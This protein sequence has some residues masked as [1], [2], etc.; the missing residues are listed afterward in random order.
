MDALQPETVCSRCCQRQCSTCAHVSPGP[1]STGVSRDP[2]IKQ[3]AA[4]SLCDS[5][6]S[7]WQA[8]PG[9]MEPGPH[10]LQ[11]QGSSSAC[12]ALRQLELRFDPG[13]GQSGACFCASK[14]APAPRPAGSPRRR[15]P[16]YSSTEDVTL[17]RH[18]DGL[19]KES[20][21]VHTPASTSEDG[22]SPD[23][24]HEGRARD[25]WGF[26]RLSQCDGNAHAVRQFQ[27]DLLSLVSDIDEMM[28]CSGK[29]P[30]E[31]SDTTVSDSHI[32]RYSYD[33]DSACG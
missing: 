14:P 7:P 21:D 3:A 2:Q 1:T 9:S 26:M 11:A 29:A 13:L 18:S 19:G 20:S 6:T 33:R 30:A 8:A 28:S 4:T 22:D 31:A 23:G 15:C 10:S 24:C 12:E 25:P 27:G 17:R 16:V 32:T 5:A